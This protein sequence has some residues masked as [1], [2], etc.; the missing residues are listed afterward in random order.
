MSTNTNA[1]NQPAINRYSCLEVIVT[2]TCDLPDC[3]EI[4]RR[5]RMLEQREAGIFVS[6][7]KAAHRGTSNTWV[8]LA[9][10]LAPASDIHRF[11][12]DEE[13]TDGICFR[14]VSQSRLLQ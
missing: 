5:Y 8:K 1:Q 14:L 12:I 13:E 3:P 10:G 11:K 7:E 9:A 4:Q 6:S 2:S